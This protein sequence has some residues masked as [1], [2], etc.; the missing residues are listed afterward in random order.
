MS[1]GK[2]KERS[3]GR[4]TRE[5]L[6]AA[7]FE[8]FG[9]KGFEGAS[10]RSICAKAGANNALLNRYY[11][12]KENLYRIVASRLFGD[13]GAP[14]AILSEGI[15]TEAQWREAVR[16]WV[17]DML[18][19]TLPTAQAQKR[20]AALFREEVTHPTKFHAEFKKNFGHPVFDALR[21]LLA[22]AIDDEQELLLWT[23]SVWAQV[24]V[25]ALADPAWHTSFRPKGVTLEV[26]ANKVRDH[27]CDNL[28]KVLKFKHA[29][30][31]GGR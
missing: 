15:S 28:F 12:T 23:S 25:Y 21:K 18:Y 17:D 10:T 31:E 7:A 9:E 1:E 14:V 13:L 11:G 16:L 29:R 5:A 19:M 6:L 3:D 8:E 20:C 27:I 2:R 24:S 26:W 30:T 22:M 4:E